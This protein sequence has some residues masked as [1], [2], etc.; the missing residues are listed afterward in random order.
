MDPGSLS[1][2][3]RAITSSPWAAACPRAITNAAVSP[4]PSAKARMRV[5]EMV[6]TPTESAAHRTLPQRPDGN[7]PER[8]HE[9]AVTVKFC[10]RRRCPASAQDNPTTE[11]AIHERHRQARRDS[12]RGQACSSIRST[13]RWSAGELTAGELGRYAGEYRHAVLALA[14]ASERAAAKA[15]SRTRS[16]T[17]RATPRRRPRTSPYGTSS[18]EA[19]GARA[20]G[21]RRAGA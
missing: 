1:S 14:E 19:A 18:R 9:L 20:R 7:Q 13:S 4:T 5:K 3:S 21:A 6:I 12:C 15:P 10:P 16:G 11:G 2:S 8:E 17:A